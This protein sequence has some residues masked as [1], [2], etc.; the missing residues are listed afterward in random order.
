MLVWK[1]PDLRLVG[2]RLFAGH[3]FCRGIK[4][5]P[6]SQGSLFSDLGAVFG[7]RVPACMLIP[8][9]NCGNG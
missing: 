9:V 7:A 3:L 5:V 8:F 1:Y 6:I 2:V 4:I